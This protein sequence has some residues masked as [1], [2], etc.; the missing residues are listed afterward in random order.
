MQRDAASVD[1]WHTR[2]K[3]LEHL[4]EYRADPKWAKYVDGM[5]LVERDETA[6]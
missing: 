1:G 5:A 4:H 2:E 3:A 6:K